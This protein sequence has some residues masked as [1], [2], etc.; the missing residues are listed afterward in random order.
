MHRMECIIGCVSKIII[1]VN[2]QPLSLCRRMIGK[3]FEY[4]S[5]ALHDATTAQDAHDLLENGFEA[6]TFDGESSTPLHMVKDGYIAAT[7]IAAG[8]NPNAQ[9]EIG[10]RPLNFARDGSIALDLLA[11]G[12][13]VVAPTGVGGLDAIH[14]VQKADVAAV[15]LAFGAD[16]NV[17]SGGTGKTPLFFAQSLKMCEILIK[18]GADVDV[19]DVLGQSPVMAMC[20][21]LKL[22]EEERKNKMKCMIEYLAMMGASLDGI[23]SEGR[24]IDELAGAGEEAFILNVRQRVWLKEM[25]EVVDTMVLN[26]KALKDGDA[27]IIQTLSVAVDIREVIFG[28]V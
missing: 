19:R 28:F 2:M 16:A 9:N 11:N 18:H 26:A 25:A 24:T 1:I 27:L 6:E 23:D 17:K 4:G 10:L 8:G 15:M 14:C 21:V 7:L 13:T 12:A 22:R 3:R 5:T 20:G